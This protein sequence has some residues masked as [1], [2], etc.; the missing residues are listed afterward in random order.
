M[1]QSASNIVVTLKCELGSL[2]VIGNIATF[3]RSHTSSYSSSIVTMAVSCVVVETER[4]IC[5]RTPIFIPDS[6]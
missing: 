6:T 3:D 4:D 2:K 5:R 1:P